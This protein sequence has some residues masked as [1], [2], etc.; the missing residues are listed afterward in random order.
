[1]NK[2]TKD[3]TFEKKRQEALEKKLGCIFIEINTSDTKRGHD[4]RKLVKYKY[5]SVNLT[6]ESVCFK[7]CFTRL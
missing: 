5:L 6:N 3:L 4:T 1:M 2:T 7:K